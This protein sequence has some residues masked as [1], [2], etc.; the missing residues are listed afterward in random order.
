MITKTD[1]IIQVPV[2]LGCMLKNGAW[3][4]LVADPN[5]YFARSYLFSTYRIPQKGNYKS[6]LEAVRKIQLKIREATRALEST[7][8]TSKNPRLEKVKHHGT[9]KQLTAG[10]YQA[11]RSKSYPKLPSRHQ[12]NNSENLDKFIKELRA[13]GNGT[14][15]MDTFAVQ[16]SKLTVEVLANAIHTHQIYMEDSELF[17]LRDATVRIL[18]ELLEM[19]NQQLNEPT[20]K[21]KAICYGTMRN[22]KNNYTSNIYEGNS[23]STR[24][25]PYVDINALRFTRTIGSPV[26]EQ[27]YFSLRKTVR[28]LLKLMG[29]RSSRKPAGKKPYLI[30][31]MVHEICSKLPPEESKASAK[32]L[33]SII[34]TYMDDPNGAWTGEMLDKCAK[35]EVGF[36]EHTS[37]A[38]LKKFSEPRAGCKTIQGV[39]EDDGWINSSVLMNIINN[40]IKEEKEDQ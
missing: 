26:T 22:I 38:A 21:L 12:I 15:T 19:K 39:P 34:K 16:N 14:I 24:V 29:A 18:S 5:D 13:E 40:K 1:G 30:R 37:A 33:S 35:S 6:A 31:D 17:S 23:S 10:Q 3:S 2:W 28:R 25:T 27:I 7:K 8:P 36:L 11:F 32:I 20:E 4:R 9:T